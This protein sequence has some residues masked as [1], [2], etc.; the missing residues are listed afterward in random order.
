MSR[1]LRI[2]AFLLC[3]LGASS[4][5]KLVTP[6][7]N[8]PVGD[9]G[10][11]NSV[12]LLFSRFRRMLK[13]L[14]CKPLSEITGVTFLRTAVMF[15]LLVLA[16]LMTPTSTRAQ[17]PTLSFVGVQ[18]SVGSG[19]YN[20][21][22]VAVDRGGDVFIADTGNGAGASPRVVEI[23]AGRGPQ[24]TVG[25]GLNYP[26]ALAV[27]GAGNLFIAD[28]GN[29]VVVK[30]PSDGGPQT[31]V[32][33]G[34]KY[35]EGVAVDGAGN[36]YIADAGNGRVVKV[37]AG[38]GTQTVVDS[39]LDSPTG[40]AVDG[41]G[42]VFITDVFT[43]DLYKVP[44]GGGTPIV[45]ASSLG[46]LWSV[47]VDSAGNLFPATKTS[48]MEISAGGV[49]TTLLG[50]G[51]FEGQFQVALDAAGDIFV[52]NL[53]LDRSAVKL[54][55]ANVCPAGKT[56]PAP[57]SQSMT[58]TYNVLSEGTVS[59]V[60]AL[61]QGAP[62]L[63]F[64]VAATTCLASL[65]TGA[66]CTVTVDFTP[67]EPGLRMGEVQLVNG[68]GTTQTIL[69]SALLYGLASG[70]AIGFNP[71]E[72]TTV[73]V[74]LPS[75]TVSSTPGT[76]APGTAAFIPSGVAVDAN[77]DV[78]VSDT[79]NNRVV[80]VPAN[81]GAQ[82][83]LGSGLAEPFGL[84]LDGAGDVFIADTGNSRVVEV[85]AGGGAQVTL[86]SGLSQPHG[87][88]VDGAGNLFIADS[89]NGRDNYG[90]LVVQGGG[91]AS[92][93]GMLTNPGSIQ[94][95]NGG[96]LLVGPSGILT[97]KNSITLASG[98]LLTDFGVVENTGTIYNS[99][100]INAE[101]SVESSF[102]NSGN[103]SIVKNGGTTDGS[104]GTITGMIGAPTVSLTPSYC[105]QIG[106]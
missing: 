85:P 69:T 24:F 11:S 1:K 14:D 86:G 65:S 96:S 43:G 22:G 90:K 37:P 84:A 63:D 21:V 87:V 60:N 3:C 31:T 32:G 41:A 30:V 49:Q 48:L 9:T 92:V 61:T 12:V 13:D 23:L 50:E 45:V 39:Q 99:G 53:E 71:N 19:F 17:T 27:D 5:V 8:P 93:G 47:A 15:V 62:D 34:L 64:S 25:S 68:S 91:V 102:V 94:V 76:T 80:E 79:Y 29:Q 75:T 81:G 95:Q 18:T 82:L 89:L 78:Y 105:Q 36:I 55:N 88:A 70:P 54:G 44:A 40:V 58:L 83:T 46:S 104:G 66:S 100:S 20:P 2:P 59:S 77:G 26:V 7:S 38:G 74:T 10:S 57:C 72:R 52:G 6:T 73:N 42:N 33:S 35:P 101:G 103:G 16:I 67:K 56:L 4:V 28:P 97:N 98:A 51:T 106:A